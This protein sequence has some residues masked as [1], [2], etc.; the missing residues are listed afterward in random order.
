Q[1]GRRASFRQHGRCSIFDGYYADAI[2]H[3]CAI[4]HV[5]PIDHLNSYASH[6]VDSCCHQQHT[7]SDDRDTFEWNYWK[8]RL[9]LVSAWCLLESSDCPFK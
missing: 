4:D 8:F 9:G 5:D 1:H 6:H 2:D 3:L 7:S